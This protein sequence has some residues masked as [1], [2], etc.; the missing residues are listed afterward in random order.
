MNQ[1]ISPLTIGALLVGLFIIGIGIRLFVDPLGLA[2]FL[3]RMQAT[4]MIYVVAVIRVG[5][6]VLLIAAAPLSRTPV[7][8]R[9]LGGLI[10][11]GGLLTP[12]YGQRIGEAI[13]GWWSS[14]GPMYIRIW[15]AIAVML[16]IMIVV[17]AFPRR[18]A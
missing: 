18:K 2:E 16:G 14:G 15:A 11:I 1:R 8:F 5:V 3:G 17:S 13:L 4:S 12:F 10:A 9:V 7:F 6:G